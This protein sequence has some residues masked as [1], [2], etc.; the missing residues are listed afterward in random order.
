M[1]PRLARLAGMRGAKRMGKEKKEK[2]RNPAISMICKGDKI[3][4]EEPH[5][6]VYSHSNIV[7]IIP[8][9]HGP[10]LSDL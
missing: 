10:R 2:Q 6:S 5:A 1:L 3:I 7:M 9:K 4:P 8:M